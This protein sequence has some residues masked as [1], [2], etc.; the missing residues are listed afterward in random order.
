MQKSRYSGR[1]F[2]S[3]RVL[4]ETGANQGNLIIARCTKDGCGKDVSLTRLELLSGT[5][6]DC[7]THT[8]IPQTPS[9]GARLTQE[10]GERLGQEL[11]AQD[12]AEREAIEMRPVREQQQRLSETL[13]QL[14]A[15][16][17]DALRAFWALD[18]Q[19]ISDLGISA[20]PIDNWVGLEPNTGT[21]DEKAELKGWV[22]AKHDLADSG[23][24]LS[25][26]GW[27]RVGSFAQVQAHKLGSD[28][29]TAESWSRCVQRLYQLGVFQDGELTGAENLDAFMNPVPVERPKPQPTFDDVLRSTDTDDRAASQR[30]KAAVEDSW[31]DDVSPTCGEWVQS[32]KDNFGIT[33]NKSQMDA[34]FSYFTK[35]NSNYNDPKAYDACRVYLVKAGNLPPTALTCGDVVSAQFETGEIDSREYFRLSQRLREQG[36]ENR[37]RA[38]ASL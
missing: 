35:T 36:L 33:L 37:P 16:E 22:D 25:D 10:Q 6:T 14:K 2:N 4:G 28:I 32:I 30:L 15:T 26:Q 34:A 21:R 24:T 23:I 11:L 27:T 5:K 12:I 1:V 13:R 38:E 18:L 3:L 29:S 19:K 9:K 7:G 31:L 20:A 17:E 8:A